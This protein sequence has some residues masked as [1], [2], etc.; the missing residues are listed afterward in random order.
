LICSFPPPSFP[1]G[2]AEEEGGDHPR[3]LRIFYSIEMTNGSG[4]EVDGLAFQFFK[5]GFGGMARQS[6]SPVERGKDG[7]VL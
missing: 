6:N 1:P 3:D 7:E 2:K 4:K 5:T